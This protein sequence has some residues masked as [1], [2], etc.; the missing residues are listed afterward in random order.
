MREGPWQGAGIG[1]GET[2]DGELTDVAVVV[3]SHTTRTHCSHP[4]IYWGLLLGHTLRLNTGRTVQPC[5]TTRLSCS[6][7]STSNL[8]HPVKMHREPVV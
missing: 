8:A 6:K 5:A 2:L 4:E 1:P 7:T 3:S